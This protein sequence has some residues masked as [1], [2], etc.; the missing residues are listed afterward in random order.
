MST[1]H[2]ENAIGLANNQVFFTELESMIYLAM[3][4]QMES[5]LYS[6]LYELAK[7]TSLV[8]FDDFFKNKTN[9]S[10][11]DM[12]EKLNLRNNSQYHVLKQFQQMLDF[13]F[14]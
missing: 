9:V 3:P 12:D 4:G 8:V 14:N 13:D 11:L 2:F 7:L 1:F 6:R 10:D 5:P